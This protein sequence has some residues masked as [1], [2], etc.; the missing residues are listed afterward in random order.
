MYFEQFLSLLKII[1]FFR[2]SF[3]FSLSV[4]SDTKWLSWLA[5][6]FHLIVSNKNQTD[7]SMDLETFKNS[8]YFKVV[9]ILKMKISDIKYFLFKA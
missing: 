7:G 8:F 5:Y 3:F 6:Q 4:K 1:F 2:I 9:C